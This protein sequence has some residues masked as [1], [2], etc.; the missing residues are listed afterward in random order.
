[1]QFSRN[2]VDAVGD[3]CRPLAQIAKPLQQLLLR[4]RKMPLHR[5]NLDTQQGQTLI[6]VVMQISRDPPA[7]LLLGFDQATAQIVKHLFGQLVVGHIHA[8]AQISRKGIIRV[9]PGH[10]HVNDPAIFSIMAAQAELYAEV[11]PQ[12]NGVRVDLVTPRH[13]LG[14]NGSHPPGSQ[15]VG[16]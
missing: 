1:M 6:D 7:L 10:A 9:E 2:G 8:R 15:F 14:M 3:V 11:F 13:I 16:K 12:S 5:A 4:Q